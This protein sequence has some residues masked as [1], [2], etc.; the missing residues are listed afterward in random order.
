VVPV[1]VVIL[2]YD[3][4]TYLPQFLRTVLATKYENFT[5]WVIDNGSPS[6]LRPFLEERYG[7][8]IQAGQ[9][10]LLRYEENM[11]Y[12]GG[13]QRFFEEHGTEVPY[14]A[15]LNSDVEVTPDWLS[16]LIRRLEAEP[17]L[18]AIQPKIRSYYQREYFEYA[19]GA[20][21]LL[22]PWGY[23]TCRGRRGFSMER[24]ED[25]Y[26]EPIPIFWASGAAFVVRTAAVQ[27]A[28]HGLLFKSHYFMHMEEIDL[29]WRLQRAGYAIG[30]EP[31]SLVYHVGG[32][33]LSQSHPQ[34][35]FYNFR[36]NLYLLAENLHPAE[37]WLIFW[38]LVL[39]GVAGIYFLLSGRVRYTWAI[40][41]AHGGF[42]RAWGRG[43]LRRER[44]LPFL[45]RRA[46]RG[47]TRTPTLVELIRTD[48]R[49]RV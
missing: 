41:R 30:Y 11:G 13:Y 49:A 27:E 48:R 3:D 36:N 9:L 14:L 39:D 28:L 20:G 7:E 33:S 4:R 47:L 34:K 5:V 19:G 38:R 12:A 37:R 29:C 15:L 44:F 8:A 21:G 25:Q 22:D 10:R 46:L 26:D 43:A 16:P 17:K 31:Q 32:A 42:Y 40:I 1:Y 6:P 35:T 23:P 24:D 45:P 2:A 18:A